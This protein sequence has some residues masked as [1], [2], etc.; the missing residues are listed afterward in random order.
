LHK[1]GVLYAVIRLALLPFFNGVPPLLLCPRCGTRRGV[2]VLHPSGAGCRGRECLNL[3][4]CT[5]R[6]T[7]Q[8][9]RD[10]RRKYLEGLLLDDDGV[11]RRPHR[12][13]IK[14]YETLVA[15]LC[16]LELIESGSALY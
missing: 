5:T 11:P 10:L 9:R 6:Q 2:I 13:R 16:E 4:W 12:M 15:E 14:V 3:T 8:E 7:P 1:A